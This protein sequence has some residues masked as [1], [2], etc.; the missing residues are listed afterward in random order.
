MKELAVFTQAVESQFDSAPTRE[1]GAVGY[2]KYLYSY[3]HNKPTCHGVF[4]SFISVFSFLS[5][6]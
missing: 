6:C 3:A 1:H 2:L 5:Q 4:L